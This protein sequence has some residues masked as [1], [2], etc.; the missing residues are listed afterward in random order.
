M[1]FYT[2]FGKMNL[3]P[4]AELLMNPEL[5]A[6]VAR[7][8]QTTEADKVA[9]ALVYVYDSNGQAVDLILDF[10]R[11]EIEKADMHSTLF[12]ANSVASKV[13]LSQSH[14]RCSNL[15]RKLLV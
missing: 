8:T 15:T 12:R 14:P 7:V 2:Q 5:A 3:D 4:L 10:I 13:F 1:H 9:K 11:R 6:L